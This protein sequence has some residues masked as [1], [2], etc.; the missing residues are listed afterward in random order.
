[1]DGAC[2]AESLNRCYVV[3]LQGERGSV[4]T[5]SM[6]QKP[7]YFSNLKLDIAIRPIPIIPIMALTDD[8]RIP[9]NNNTPA[10]NATMSPTINRI[11]LIVLPLSIQLYYL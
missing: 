7:F 5:D 11:I 1:M 2:K 6:T 8:E 10:V 3:S 4:A 9:K